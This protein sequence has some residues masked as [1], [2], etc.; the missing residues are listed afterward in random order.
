MSFAK[1]WRD[2]GQLAPTRRVLLVHGGRGASS[3]YKT[4]VSNETWMPGGGLSD[5]LV[6]KANIAMATNPN[7][8]VVALLWHQG[9]SDPN[10]QRSL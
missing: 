3:F 9:E 10:D 8:K 4:D 2:S 1:Q 7:N 5:D 6:K